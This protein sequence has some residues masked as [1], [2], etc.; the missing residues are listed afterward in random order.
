MGKGDRR[1]RRGE[2]QTKVRTERE[3]LK[4]VGGHSSSVVIKVSTL[5]RGQSIQLSASTSRQASWRRLKMRSWGQAASSCFW[6]TASNRRLQSGVWNNGG[7]GQKGL[8]VWVPVRC[9]GKWLPSFWEKRVY[10]HT[11]ARCFRGVMVNTKN[12]GSER[13]VQSAPELQRLTNVTFMLGFHV[14]PSS[15]WWTLD[16][17]S[18]MAPFNFG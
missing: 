17:H 3:K 12:Q 16:L 9:Q 13:D 14:E 7:R 5:K 6:E 18:H 1:R 2:R 4:E 8:K 15:T 10:S 11:G